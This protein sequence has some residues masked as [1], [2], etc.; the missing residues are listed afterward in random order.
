MM[1]EMEMTRL[2]LKT[3]LMGMGIVGAG[4]GDGLG[5]IVQNASMSTPDNQVRI[6]IAGPT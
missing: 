6:I 5:E 1:T 3:S 2:W 4:D